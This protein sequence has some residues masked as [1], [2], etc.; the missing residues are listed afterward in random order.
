MLSMKEYIYVTA[1]M[2]VCFLSC[3]FKTAEMIRGVYEGVVIGYVLTT[4]LLY[5]CTFLLFALLKLK[6][7]T[8]EKDSDINTF[9][10]AK[11]LKRIS[12]IVYITVALF[13]ASSLFDVLNLRF[14]FRI[15]LDPSSIFSS[16]QLWEVILGITILVYGFRCYMLYGKEKKTY[17]ILRFE[18]MNQRP[19][20]VFNVIKQY[21]TAEEYETMGDAA[22]KVSEPQ[23]KEKNTEQERFIAENSVSDE[24]INRKLRGA[25]EPKNRSSD[26]VPLDID[27]SGAKTAAPRKSKECPL[28]GCMNTAGSK[29]CSFCGSELK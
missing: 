1:I 28:C 15:W 19:Q 5:I 17:S 7:R 14:W 9:L 25:S 8:F 21:P 24:E 10:V 22:L 27:F 18:Q 12:E 4:F 26:R 3:V 11:K 29:E 23:P 16:Y 2:T 20:S 6:C 13:F